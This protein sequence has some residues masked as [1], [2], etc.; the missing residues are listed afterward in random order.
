MRR[1]ATLV[2]ITLTVIGTS[3]AANA[4]HEKKQRKAQAAERQETYRRPSTVDYRGLC[5]RDNGR[6]SASL[7]L[8]QRCDREEFFQRFNDFGGNRR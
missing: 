5:Q 3:Q 4:N 6:P 7:N 2:L 8:N 1:L